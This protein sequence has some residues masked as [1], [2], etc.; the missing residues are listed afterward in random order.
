VVEPARCQVCGFV[1]KKRDRLTSPGRCPSCRSSRIEEP[2][3][4]IQKR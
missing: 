2:L 4:T 3:F 1:F